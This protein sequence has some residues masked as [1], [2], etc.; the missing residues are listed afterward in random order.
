MLFVR[1]VLNSNAYCQLSTNIH[2]KLWVFNMKFHQAKIWVKI[3]Q[4]NLDFY[5]IC[6]T[7][8]II[9]LRSSYIIH[10]NISVGWTEVLD[11]VINR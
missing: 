6:T 10:F 3:L 1:Y 9:F 8:A 11:F 4:R 2:Y 7:S 5:M